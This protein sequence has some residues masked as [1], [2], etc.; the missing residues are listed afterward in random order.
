MAWPA[1]GRDAVRAAREE[2]QLVIEDLDF[3]LLVEAEMPGDSSAQG[4]G[5]PAF[6]EGQ[7]SSAT[8]DVCNRSGSEVSVAYATAEGGTDDAGQTLFRSQGWRNVPDGACEVLW[9]GPFAN[10]FYYVFAQADDGSYGGDFHFCTL[11]SRFDIV[12]TQ[13]SEDYEREGFL[14]IDMGQ[15]TRM[16]DGFQLNLTP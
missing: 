13:C 7:A 16:S 4:G 14:Q 2:W 1:D 12:D 15:G 8:L 5:G 9:T 3:F 10:R 6:A 11:E